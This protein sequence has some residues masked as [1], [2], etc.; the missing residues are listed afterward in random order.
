M[1]D[2][3]T[4]ISNKLTVIFLETRPQF[5]ILTPMC[6]LVGIGTASYAL[7]GFAKIHLGFALL[8][9]IGALFAH[10]AVNVLNDYFDFRSGI[11][12][13]TQPTAFSGG[14]GILPQ[15]LMSPHG[16]LVLGIFS[17]LSVLAIGLF[18]VAVRGWEI[19][20]LGLTGILLIVLYTSIITKSPIFCLIGPGLGFGPLMVAGTH[21]VLTGRYD[22]IAIYASLIPGFLVS[23]LLLLNQFPDIEADRA[24]NRRHLPLLIGRQASAY[25]YGLLAACAFAW[26]LVAAVF[27]LLPAW[28]LLA[29]APLTLAV[30]TVRGVIRHA[31]K[32]DLLIPFLKK[33]VL[34]TLATPFALSIGLLMS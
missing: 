19:L 23:N 21:F 15:G 34:Y 9:T 22:L 2:K 12:L 28:T 5:L 17:L 31:N 7:G 27:E 13:I 11:D 32:I 8:A 4:L 10:I 26:I 20:P 3:A 18:F 14:S 30:I 1:T 6:V 33:N 29:L 25:L 24:G 16:V